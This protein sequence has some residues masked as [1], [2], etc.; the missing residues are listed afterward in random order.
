MPETKKARAIGFNH[1][2]LEVG[3][4]DEALSFYGRIFEFTLRGKSENMA[5]IDL[6]DQF[7]ALQKG[8]LQPPDDGRHFGLVVDDK[9]T[10]REALT[11]AGIETLPGPFLDFRD[12][13]GN[14]VEIVGYADIQFSKAPNI[15]RGMGLTHLSKTPQAL[16]ELSEKG[17]APD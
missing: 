7:L 15:L 14:R 6:G 11:A 8:R 3:D 13:W 10:V 9:N 16:K 4:I 12:P 5:F 1:I 2:A 17:M